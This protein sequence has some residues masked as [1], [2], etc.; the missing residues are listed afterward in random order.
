MSSSRCAFEFLLP[1][2]M[3]TWNVLVKVRFFPERVQTV[4]SLHKLMNMKRFTADLSL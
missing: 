4:L 2:K 3:Y 1:H